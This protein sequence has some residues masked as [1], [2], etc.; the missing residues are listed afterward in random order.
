LGDKW[1]FK[2]LLAPDEWRDGKVAVKSMRAGDPSWKPARWWSQCLS[3][4][5][6]NGFPPQ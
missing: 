2:H 6:Q 3:K 1:V 5:W 4:S